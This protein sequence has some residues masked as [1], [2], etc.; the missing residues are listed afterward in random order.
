MN[1]HVDSLAAAVAPWACILAGVNRIDRE[2]DG[3]Y[4]QMRP[5]PD[6]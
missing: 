5:V 3:R 6:A 4:A 1:A 2:Y